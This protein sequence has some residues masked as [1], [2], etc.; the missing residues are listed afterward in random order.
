[1]NARIQLKFLQTFC[2][3]RENWRLQF[4]SFVIHARS[5]S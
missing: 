2:E 5:D 1:M 3:E 4:V